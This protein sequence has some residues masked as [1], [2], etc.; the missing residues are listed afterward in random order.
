M[1]IHV[2]IVAC[3]GTASTL[4]AITW[5]FCCQTS[6]P[7]SHAW[8]FRYPTSMARIHAT[9]YFRSFGGSASSVVGPSA[10]SSMASSRKRRNTFTKH[11]RQQIEWLA[12]RSWTLL[13]ERDH[14]IIFLYITALDH[15]AM[16]RA[17]TTDSAP[18]RVFLRTTP[19]WVIQSVWHIVHQHSP[20]FSVDESGL[21]TCRFKIR[22][23][24]R[25]SRASY[26]YSYAYYYN[27]YSTST[28]P[29]T[30]RRI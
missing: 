27:H 5:V 8:F 15:N 4:S 10:R 11:D 20:S 24:I 25:S 9:V 26:Y 29:I 14:G 1:H 6:M 13:Q 18:L 22:K 17:M 30:W 2:C 28:T 16:D 7:Y 23:C 3:L 21:V 12:M 19:L